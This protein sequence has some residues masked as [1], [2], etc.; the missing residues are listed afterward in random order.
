MNLTA[1]PSEPLTDAEQ[2]AAICEVACRDHARSELRHFY[3]MVTQDG[4]RYPHLLLRLCQQHAVAHF[5][6]QQVWD[7]LT[8]ASQDSIRAFCERHGYHLHIR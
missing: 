3:N 1:V 6:G 5:T 4:Q 7:S 8:E 2:A